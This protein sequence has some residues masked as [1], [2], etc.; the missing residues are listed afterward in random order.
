MNIKIPQWL[1][2]QWDKFH[3]WGY[4]PLWKKGWVT[5]RRVDPLILL[6]AVFCAGYYYWTG[7]WQAAATGLLMFILV[8]MIALWIL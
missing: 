3:E 6:A 8:G 1:A 2:D 5:I 7:G 4:T